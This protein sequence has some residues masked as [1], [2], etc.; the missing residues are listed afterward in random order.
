MDCY[1]G[2]QYPTY[3]SLSRRAAGLS[4]ALD[5]GNIPRDPSIQILGLKAAHITYLRANW[6]LRVL[7]GGCIS[8]RETLTTLDP[9]P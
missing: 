2:G 6:D 3:R 5:G 1:W 9:N 7:P 8:T 4:Y